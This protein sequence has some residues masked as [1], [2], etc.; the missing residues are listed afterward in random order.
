MNRKQLLKRLTL[1]SV[2]NV[3]FSDIINLVEGFGFKLDRIRGSHHLF[4]H[5][6]IPEILNLQPDGKQAKPYQ[7][8]QF[9]R[10]IEE[11]EL[12]LED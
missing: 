9:L 6:D 2:Q 3:Q 5:P 7:I 12:N 10:L 8:R 1:G 11:R 4:V